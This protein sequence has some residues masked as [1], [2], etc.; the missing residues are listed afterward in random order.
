VIATVF[1]TILQHRSLAEATGGLCK[2]AEYTRG[3][4]KFGKLLI[5]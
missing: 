3:L 2:N 5:Y 1:N 4:W